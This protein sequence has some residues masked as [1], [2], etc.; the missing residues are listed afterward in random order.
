MCMIS[1]PINEV[2]NTNLFVA[3]DDEKQRQLTVYSNLVDNNINANAMV[4]PVPHPNTVQFHD[5]STYKTFFDDCDKSFKL[6]SLTRGYG[7]T[8]STNSFNFSADGIKKTIAIQTVGS[9]RVS[10]VPSINELEN[11]DENIFVLSD[12]LKNILAEHYNGVEWGFIVFVLA[13]DRKEYHP[14][15]W[16]HNLLNGQIYIPTRHYHNHQDDENVDE[17]LLSY[18]KS[19]INMKLYDASNIDQSPMFSSAFI[20]SLNKNSIQF[21]QSKQLK[22][23][24]NQNNNNMADDWSHKIYLYNI[25]RNTIKN[26][27][28][29]KKAVTNKYVYDWDYKFAFDK[30][31]FNNFSM[32]N[33]TDFTKFDID[34][35]HANNDIMI[36]VN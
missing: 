19:Q 17:D 12:G 7:V 20:P 5:L 8:L 15:A 18:G 25:D 34:G 28:F 6:R 4:I 13:T 33:H 11:I 16:S 35:Y 1:L 36:D 29:I 31:K 27:D 14:F 24:I 2:T 3:L 23:Q 30:S 22:Q 10:V 26:N 9:Y 32:E 21:K